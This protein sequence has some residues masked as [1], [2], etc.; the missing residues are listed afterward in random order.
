VRGTGERP[1]DRYVD[2]ERLRTHSSTRRPAIQRGDLAVCYAA[3]WQELFAIVR[4]S[5]HPEHDPTRTRWSWRI[6]LE[7]LVWID[8]LDSAP[9]SRAAGIMPSSLG[10]HSYVRLSRERFA[11]ASELIAAAVVPAA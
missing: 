3:A 10:R 11:A 7:P 5:G 8:D 2:P 1:L 4:V 9:P 6:P